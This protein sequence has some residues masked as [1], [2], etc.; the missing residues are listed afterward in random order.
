MIQFLILLISVKFDDIQEQ[1]MAKLVDV[2]LVFGVEVLLLLNIVEGDLPVWIFLLFL[3]K[4]V[5]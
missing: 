2:H 4:F 1:V 3:A 5:N